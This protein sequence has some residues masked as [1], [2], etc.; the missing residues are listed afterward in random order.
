[1]TV[2]L[3]MSLGML[4][5]S[6]VPRW[7]LYEPLFH[8]YYHHHQS[9][10][11]EPATTT[12]TTSNHTDEQA[13]T[14]QKFSQSVAAASFHIGMGILAYKVLRHK[15]WMWQMDEWYPAATTRAHLLVE[16]DV[17][18]YYLLYAARYIS[19]A[20]SLCFEHMRSVSC[21]RC[22]YNVDCPFS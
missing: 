22:L 4:L 15:P 12:T 18:A 16:V 17:K 7:Y 9:R 5:L 19:D 11:L 21:G 6:W 13:I 2:L 10:R 3:A 1:M 14:A 20:V 8:Y